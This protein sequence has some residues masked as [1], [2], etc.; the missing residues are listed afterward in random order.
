MIDI[1]QFKPY[2]DHYGHGGGR[3]AKNSS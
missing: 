1:D 2:N 3:G